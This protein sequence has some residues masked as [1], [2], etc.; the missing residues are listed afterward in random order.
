MDGMEMQP[1]IKIGDAS[2]ASPFTSKMPSIRGCVDIIRQGRCTLVTTIQMYQI[3][4]LNCLIN[5]YAL[6][7]LH[8]DGIKYGDKQLT[9]L[10]MLM[11]VS[12]ISVSRSQPL[13]KLS[14]IKPLKS[15]FHPAYFLSL[16]GQFALHLG[17]YTLSPIIVCIIL[18][19]GLRRHDVFSGAGV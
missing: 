10:G 11:S 16:L 17:N 9:C 14:N 8:L 13:D 15:V 18:M 3:L 1:M 7:S 2:V 12:F 5:A 19:T 6:S 4:A